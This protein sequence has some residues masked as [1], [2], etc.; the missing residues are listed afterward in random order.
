MA[1]G[2]KRDRFVVESIQ[3]HVEAE[4]ASLGWFAMDS[5]HTPLTLLYEFPDENATVAEN[6]LAMS[7][8]NTDPEYVELGSLSF[9]K[10]I[11]FYCDFYGANDAIAIHLIGDIENFF[12]K[13]PSLDVYDYENGKV[14]LF[15]AQVAEVMARRPTRV[16]Q[17]WQK[18]WYTLSV[19]IED[20]LR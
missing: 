14:V 9:Q 3:E 20:E 12:M 7:T 16:T 15:Q 19:G 5:T 11:L 18:H 4:L 17:P 13:N 1:D 6:T 8:G 10:E 2:G